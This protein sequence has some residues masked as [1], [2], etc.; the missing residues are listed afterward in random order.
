MIEVEKKIEDILGVG[1]ARKGDIDRYESVR[2]AMANKTQS[3]FVT[4]YPNI[5]FDK[6]IEKVLTHIANLLK[7]C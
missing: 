4:A 7:I 2:N 6:T 3:D 5:G 1:K